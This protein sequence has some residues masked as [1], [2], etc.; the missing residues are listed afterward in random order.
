[1]A[2]AEW[3]EDEWELIINADGFVYKRKK[4]RRLNPTSSSSSSSAPPPPPPDPAAEEKNRRERKKRA[5]TK[6]RDKYQKEIDQWEHLSN[7][8]RALQEKSQ[9]QQQ[10]DEQTPPPPALSEKSSDTGGER[11]LD[12]LLHRAETEEAVIQ[13]VSNLCDMA[14]AICNLQ[15]ESMKQSLLDLPVWASPHELLSSLCDN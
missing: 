6:L 13:S 12:D 8:L 1:M 15:E 9:N 10:C 3:E 14:E 11:L 2:T 7:M 5:L 4:R